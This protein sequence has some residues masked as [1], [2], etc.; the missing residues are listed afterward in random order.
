MSHGDVEA[1]PGPGKWTGRDDFMLDPH[2]Y[3]F[4][5]RHLCA[6]GPLPSIDAFAERHN[7]QCP[8]FWSPASDALSLS[9]YQATPLWVN[10]PFRY[11]RRIIAKLKQEGGWALIIGPDTCIQD[12]K[13]VLPVRGT[14]HLPAKPLYRMR[15]ARLMPAPT[16]KTVAVLVAIPPPIGMPLFS[17]PRRPGWLD[18]GL[19]I[20]FVFTKDLPLSQCHYPAD[21]QPK[22]TILIPF[23]DR[24]F[25]LSRHAMWDTRFPIHG[26]CA[27][28]HNHHWPWECLSPALTAGPEDTRTVCPLPT[29]LLKPALSAAHWALLLH[30]TSSLH[31][32]PRLETPS[33]HRTPL[34]HKG[35]TTPPTTGRGSFLPSCGDIETNPGPSPGAQAMD[36]DSPSGFVDLCH[37]RPILPGSED[38]TPAPLSF[39]GEDLSENH[40]SG[41]ARPAAPSDWDVLQVL[42]AQCFTA[43]HIPS[44]I[45]YE[46]RNAL[47]KLLRIWCQDPSP[48]STFLLLAFPKLVLARCERT[49][50]SHHKQQENH[51]RR[52]LRLFAEGQWLEL[53]KALNEGPL[54]S[55]RRT[56]STTAAQGL[57]EKDLQSIRT[58]ISEG[59]AG[60]VLRNL[61]S[62]GLHDQDDPDVLSKLKTLHPQGPDIVRNK[63]PSPD[64]VMDPETVENNFWETSA[65]DVVRSFPPASAPGPSGLRPVHLKELL[66]R[67]GG[68]EG[69]LGHA[70]GQF[71]KRCG[72]GNLVGP[73]ASAL[74]AA[75][76]IPLRKK[77]DGVRPV[78]IGDTLRRV[79]G[80][81]LLQIPEVSAALHK[82]APLQTGLGTPNAAESVAMGI[83]KLLPTLPAE[84]G[85]AILQIDL[86]NA[87]NCVHRDS[88]LDGTR[89]YAP[90][91]FNWLQTM[92]INQSPLFLGQHIIQS[93]SGVHQGCPLGPAGFALG[94]HRILADLQRKPLWFTSFYLDDGILI[95]PLEDLANA[96]AHLARELAEVGCLINTEK[97]VLWG[98]GLSKESIQGFNLPGDHPFRHVASPRFDAG[99]GITVLGIPVDPPG[100]SA[101]SKAAFSNSIQA[102][103]RVCDT[104]RTIHDPQVAHCL[105]RQ[106]GDAGRLNFLLRS[107]GAVGS[108]DILHEADSIIL[109]CF[110]DSLH[111]HLD[112]IR[113]DQVQLPVHLGGCGIR[114]PTRIWPAARLASVAVFL[115]KGASICGI[116]PQALQ[117]IP[118]DIPAVIRQAM[119]HL[120]QHFH[121]LDRWNSQGV[122]MKSADADHLSQRWWHEQLSNC[123]AE[124]L[125]RS[126]AGR[127]LT[128]Y[129]S[130]TGGPAGQWMTIKPSP[131]LR[132]LIPREDYLIGMRWHLGLPIIPEDENFL[133]SGCQRPVDVYGDH[134]VSCPRNNFWRRH[135]AVQETLLSLASQAGVPHL[136]E[137]PLERERRRGRLLPNVR[138][139][140]IL[141]RHWAGGK[142]SAVDCTVSHPAQ[143]S[144]HPLTGDKARS[145]L[146]R[147]EADKLRKYEDICDNEGW[148]FIPFGMNT[149]GGVGPHG[150]SLLNRLA[151]KA[152]AVADEAD[153]REEDDNLRQNLALAVM[154]EVWRLLRRRT[155]AESCT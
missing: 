125:Q 141:L 73:V 61:M 122:L 134:L 127:D 14:I 58:L 42:Q 135:N 17:S 13:G 3:R 89:R 148:D 36:E 31:Q 64:L 34:L 19:E 82:L 112:G 20:P 47:T 16:W 113:R 145:F 67:D 1:N 76:L 62:E 10:P 84:P 150:T 11:F 72:E 138:P 123:H 149:W 139:A 80:K 70:L 39:L 60:K 126:L 40:H 7:A 18:S 29:F 132:T 43:R 136:R 143:L 105:L 91:L 74:S 131:A 56:R 57:T 8:N 151:R 119:M 83:Q 77:G 88:V 147:V 85:W 32:A 115:S 95:G 96:F 41:N 86:R 54:P 130:Q 71:A 35:S 98:P 137:A 52:R 102:L 50:K 78:A 53:R 55:R 38:P 44:G 129:V 79:T 51:I 90:G 9:W 144:E 114:T 94:I 69:S 104:I 111:L 103:R 87:F 121:P 66:K 26:P 30:T 93:A 33:T 128:R 100:I 27:T 153:R 154:R 12:L 146:R 120:G 142:D 92:L 140:D 116:P 65:R 97:C 37:Q 109:S 22:E 110:E 117:S 23:G 101:G 63:L 75:T 5:I 59:A 28:C 2:W 6:P 46:V 24:T 45:R 81:V 124:A 99:E 21:T 107:T 118:T 106:C 49:G 152:T 155:T 48:T 133:C 108:L 68:G 4:L 15:G 25:V